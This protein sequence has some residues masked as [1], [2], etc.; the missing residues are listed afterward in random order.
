MDRH[1][2]VRGLSFDSLYRF[3]TPQQST[4]LQRSNLNF[5]QFPKRNVRLGISLHRFSC[6]SNFWRERCDSASLSAQFFVPFQEQENVWRGLIGENYNRIAAGG[7]GG[8]TPQSALQRVLRLR[9]RHLSGFRPLQGGEQASNLQMESKGFVSDPL[10]IQL[11][12]KLFEIERRDNACRG[13]KPPV[14]PR[15]LLFR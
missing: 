15:Y 4:A 1:T 5:F 9:L 13:I 3:T 14:V 7:L 6:L 12:P 11:M 8:R 2:A 10:Y